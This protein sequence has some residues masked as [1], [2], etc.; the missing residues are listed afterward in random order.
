MS[1]RWSSSERERFARGLRRYQVVPGEPGRASCSLRGAQVYAEWSSAKRAEFERSVSFDQAVCG[2][3]AFN[4]KRDAWNVERAAREAAA[5]RAE[6]LS[7][8]TGS[9]DRLMWVDVV[10]GGT[11]RVVDERRVEWNARRKARAVPRLAARLGP[12]RIG[13]GGVSGRALVSS[14]VWRARRLLEVRNVSPGVRER[15]EVELVD[16]LRSLSADERLDLVVPGPVNLFEP[17]LRLVDVLASHG[18]VL[19]PGKEGSRV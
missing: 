7:V 13:P 2:V 6:A 19:F 15:N 17:D 5:A 3:Q 18:F 1:P 11:A 8:S 12:V 14:P 16:W 10:S 4:A 9:V